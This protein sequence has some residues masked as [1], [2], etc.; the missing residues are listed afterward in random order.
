M[1]KPIEKNHT[2]SLFSRLKKNIPFNSKIHTLKM[3]PQ[4]PAKQISHF[5]KQSI[6]NKKS[7]VI[8]INTINEDNDVIEIMGAP[9]ISTHSGH[10]ILKENSKIIHLVQANTI[11]HIRYV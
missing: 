7:I 9:F 8:Q 1:Q 10:L 2:H 3:Q 4:M 5:A 6:Q 11:R